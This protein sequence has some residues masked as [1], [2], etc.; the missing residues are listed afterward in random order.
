MDGNLKYDPPVE[1][2]NL[3]GGQVRVQVGRKRYLFGTLIRT[4][5][6]D[7]ATVVTDKGRTI[8]TERA[9]VQAR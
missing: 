5:V 2:H 4:K 8:Q 6:K 1:Q 9:N 7:V 3:D